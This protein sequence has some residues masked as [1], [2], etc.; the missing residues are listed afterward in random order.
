MASITQ[1]EVSA[2]SGLTR[3]LRDSIVE[4]RAFQIA[5]LCGS[6]AETWDSLSDPDQ[7]RYTVAAQVALGYRTFPDAAAYARE[8]YAEWQYGRSFNCLASG[9]QATVYHRVRRI[10]HDAEIYLIGFAAPMTS[11]TRAQTVLGAKRRTD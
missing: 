11:W 4:H 3:Q 10:L 8:Q 2:E 9:Q 5:Q 6:K 7:A 1:L